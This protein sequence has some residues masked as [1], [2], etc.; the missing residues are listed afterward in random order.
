MTRAPRA[1]T[2]AA[3]VVAFAA[4]VNDFDALF[5]ESKVKDDADGGKSSSSSSS[6]GSTGDD[7]DDATPPAAP[8]A[9]TGSDCTQKTCEATSKD[10]FD[11]VVRTADQCCTYDTTCKDDDACDTT[12]T[13]G[14]IC[15]GTCSTGFS[16]DF[17]VSGKSTQAVLKCT[18][19]RCFMTCAGGAKCT[20]DCAADD[21]TVK[22]DEAST[23]VV[24][25]CFNSFCDV[26]CGNG[27]PA[28]SCAGGVK[29]C[30]GCPE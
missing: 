9:S 28:E 19:N 17:E 16:C 30:G 14:A 1:A 12:C 5:D 21:C 7:D 8:D 10:T 24:Q 4:C 3:V 6:S 11:G 22:C 13:N 27:K 2:I 29:A 23:C 18:T 25:H 26:R 15:S 20:L